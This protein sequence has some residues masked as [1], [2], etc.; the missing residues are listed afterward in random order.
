MTDQVVDEVSEPITEKPPVDKAIEIQAKIDSAVKSRLAREKEA[1]KAEAQAWTEEKDT[2]TQELEYLRTQM[3]KVLDKRMGEVPTSFK[4]VLA[5]LSIQDQ[6]AWLDEQDAE[7]TK[8]PKAQQ[9]PQ[10]MH[11]DNPDAK[12]EVKHMPLDKIV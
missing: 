12:P 10:F 11:K 3:Q 1:H 4:T 7:E 6:I 8:K 9:I 2:L 5:K